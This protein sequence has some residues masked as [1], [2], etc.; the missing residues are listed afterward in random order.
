[1]GDNRNAVASWGCG[2]NDP[3]YQNPVDGAGRNR[4]AG[5]MR[6]GTGNPG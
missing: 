1:M 2:R 4:V 3:D 5:G 6:L